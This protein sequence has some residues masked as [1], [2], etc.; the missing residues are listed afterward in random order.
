M[1]TGQEVSC[2]VSG[3]VLSTAA[4]WAIQSDEHLDLVLPKEE[5]LVR[6]VKTVSA[7]AVETMELW[8][9]R[10]PEKQGRRVAEHRPLTPGNENLA[11]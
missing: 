3:K 8:S 10:S 4:K 5:K 7:L 1:Q 6:D 9:P 11:C 2:G